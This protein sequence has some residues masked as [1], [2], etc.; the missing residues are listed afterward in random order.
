MKAIR[1]SKQL[2]SFDN[3]IYRLERTV[4]GQ[5]LA[6]YVAVT[7]DELVYGRRGVARELLRA[8]KSLRKMV[9]IA[10]LLTPA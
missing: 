3:T 4:A 1:Y 2:A 9:T 7:A 5:D 8:R 10:Q 6:V